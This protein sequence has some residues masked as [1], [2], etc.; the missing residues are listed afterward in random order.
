MMLLE[1]GFSSGNLN[2]LTC[3]AILVMVDLEMVK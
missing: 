1:V 3:G 2:K